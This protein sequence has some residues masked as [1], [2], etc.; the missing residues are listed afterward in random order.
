[1]K[2]ITRKFNRLKLRRTHIFTQVKLRR[3]LPRRHSCWR[4]R[5]TLKKFSYWSMSLEVFVGGGVF[6]LDTSFLATP[7]VG[8]KT[9]WTTHHIC[10][11]RDIFLFGFVTSYIMQKYFCIN[12]LKVI[13]A[14]FECIPVFLLFWDC[15]L[16][17]FP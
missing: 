13:Y 15:Q 11:R 8:V 10:C 6:V 17:W 7:G 1:M 4:E 16:P 3:P 12:C 5:W 14:R 9:Q 2:P